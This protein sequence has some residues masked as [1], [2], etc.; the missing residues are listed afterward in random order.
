[1]MEFLETYWSFILMVGL[2]F[3]MLFVMMRSESKRKKEGEKLRASLAVG[4]VVTTVGGNVGTVCAVKENT[5]VI[6]TGADRVRMEF[7]KAAV[8]SRGNPNNAQ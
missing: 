3:I 7:I 6:E 1:M 8:S 5:F 2:M 4:D